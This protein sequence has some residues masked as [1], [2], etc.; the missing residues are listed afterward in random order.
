MAEKD[1]MLD[2]TS[3]ETIA[4]L[5][6]SSTSMSVVEV[7][8]LINLFAGLLNTSTSLIL[9]RLD[10]NAKMASERWMKHDAELARNR[11]A[12][13]ARF[14]KIEGVLDKDVKTLDE[15]LSKA[16]DDQVALDARVRPVMTLAGAVQRNWKTILL[17]IVAVLAILGFSV[18][19][20]QRILGA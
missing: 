18:E 9:G 5:Q 11:D 17:F 1:P 10:E 3:E 13:V 12:I 15:H 19:T 6:R 2:F 16:H 14:E 20:F 8:G 7:T 4:E